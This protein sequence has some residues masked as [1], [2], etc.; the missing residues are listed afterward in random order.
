MMRKHYLYLVLLMLVVTACRW[1]TAGSQST[2]G[3]T[4]V[5]QQTPDSLIRI[6]VSGVCI[7]KVEHSDSSYMVHITVHNKGVLRIVKVDLVNNVVDSSQA[8]ITVYPE[9]CDIAPGDSCQLKFWPGLIPQS[10][11]ERGF[12]TEKI[13][14]RFE[15]DEVKLYDFSQKKLHFQVTDPELKAIL[16]KNK[17]LNEKYPFRFLGRA[18]NREE[19]FDKC[20]YDVTTE[21]VEHLYREYDLRYDK[22][23]N[24]YVVAPKKLYNSSE[25]FTRLLKF[26]NGKQVAARTF[27]NW[28]ASYVFN[29]NNGYLVGLNSLATTS[30]GQK[31]TFYCKT[32]L[33]DVDLNTVNERIFKYPEQKDSYYAYTYID[34]LYKVNDGYRF[35]VINSGFDPSDYYEYTGTLSKTNVVIESS[36]RNV[37]IE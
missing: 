37:V 26:K 33:L 22:A 17:M 16:Q 32:V 3:N 9:S 24:I 31:S 30:G 2:E 25:Y 5:R 10:Y 11:V 14:V 34:T 13:A 7:E 27:Y 12:H 19:N 1:G 6:G 20:P 4:D 21:N 15:N 35:R 8:R 23:T 36:K 28:H 18:H 29:N